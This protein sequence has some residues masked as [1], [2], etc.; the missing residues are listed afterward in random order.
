M[1]DVLLFFQNI[2]R[3]NALSLESDCVNQQFKYYPVGKRESITSYGQPKFCVGNDLK[4]YHYLCHV[5][6][7]LMKN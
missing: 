2:L 1:A 4:N 3:P 5:G 7:E 6:K